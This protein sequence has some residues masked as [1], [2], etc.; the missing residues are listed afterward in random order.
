MN[1]LKEGGSHE[2][3]PTHYVSY[4]DKSILGLFFFTSYKPI[5]L[6][7]NHPTVHEWMTYI[8]IH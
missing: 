4:K 2:I 5:N 6:G 1:T 8:Y 3:Y 7:P